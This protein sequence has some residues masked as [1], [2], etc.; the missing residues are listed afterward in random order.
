MKKQGLLVVTV[1]SL[2]LSI[3][4]CNRGH[5]LPN[6]GSSFEENSTFSKESSAQSIESESSSL[7]DT[8]SASSQNSFNESSGIADCNE[9]VF[10]ETTRPA[11]IIEKGAIVRTCEKCGYTEESNFSYDLNE[12]VFNDKTYM[13]DGTERELLIE[14]LIPY[15]TTVR[16]ENNK[17]AE[18]GSQVATA[19]IYDENN[20]LLV[21]KNATIT[22]V[23]NVGLPNI[24]VTT[25][26]GKDPDYH[27]KTNYTTMTASIDN[28]E[29][30][31][32]ISSATGGIRARGNSTNYDVVSKLPWRLKFDSKVN[33]LGLNE[34][35][36]FKSWVLLAEYFDQ[37]LLRN[38]FAFTMGNSLFNYS[39]NYCSDFKHVNFY[40]NGDYRGVYL[41]AEQQQCNTGRFGIAEPEDATSEKVGY[42]V[43]IDIRGGDDDPYFT[44][45]PQSYRNPQGVWSGGIFI[46][47]VRVVSSTYAI[48]SD[49]F[50]NEQKKYIEKYISNAMNALIHCVTGEKLEIVNENNELVDSPY[51]NQFD[52]LN[53]FIDIESF[54][55]ICILHELMKNYDVGFG[56]FYLFVDFSNNSKHKRLTFGAPWDFDL[57]SGN[58][59]SG[60]INKTD[61]EFIKAGFGEANFNP[62]LY[63]ISQTDFYD[64]LI[65]KYYSV[66]ANSGAF[67]NAMDYIAYATSAFATDFVN[68]F[69]RW[70]NGTGKDRMQTRQYNSQKDA[71]SYLSNWLNKR[72]QYMDSVYLR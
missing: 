46:N 24:R 26:T 40:M 21:S 53:S 22:I 12:F 44:C 31:Y 69:T 20:Q 68:E 71:S 27:D 14:G 51:D 10:K 6:S 45:G 23:E 30:K 66:F 72:K 59:Q 34:G 57:S 54:L 39:N 17:L 15:G 28:C 32:V 19:S 67:D 35:K 37:S 52:T 7:L 61:N 3:S 60:N 36:K 16:Y 1:L 29:Q 41:L 62:W 5:A 49:T 63:L 2:V 33:L 65:K 42:L 47:G 48:K 38:S 70:K 25:S 43:E 64:E 50:S 56:S 58:K 4:A 8:N 9:H 18:I 13:Y 55:K 11:S